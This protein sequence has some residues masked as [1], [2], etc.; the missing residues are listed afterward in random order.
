MSTELY[1]LYAVIAA[2][3]LA[4]FAFCLALIVR[5]FAKMVAV[6]GVAFAAG[7]GGFEETV[8]AHKAEI[9][10][11]RDL[12]DK[13]EK[14]EIYITSFDGLKLHGVFLPNGGSRRVMLFV[15]GYRSSARHD[16]A[17]A[18]P[19]YIGRGYAILMIDQRAHGQSEGDHIT[20]GVHERRDICDFANE[21]DRRFGGDVQI[22]L[23]GISMGA[24]T[25]LFAANAG[26]PA[27]VRGIIAD[28][29]YTSPRDI[30]AYLL[31]EKYRLPAFPILPLVCR[32]L[33]K[34]TG[35]DFG[36]VSVANTL[37]DNRL[38]ILF[39][40]GEEDGFV[41][42]EMSEAAYEITPSQKTLVRVPGAPHACGYLVDRQ[43]CDAALDRF[44]GAV[45]EK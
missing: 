5:K 17:A 15:H 44:L 21:L 8:E 4:V 2:V 41:P 12:Y 30:L 10:A 18:L 23:D 13:L 34:L 28:S 43:N 7:F 3:I 36:S 14:E 6:R 33:R 25:V 38:P 9:D 11:G 45:F 1:I 29:G 24:A 16:F 40:H 42:I 20:L 26:L 32:R 22:V 19:Y 27:S 39:V 31:R 35:A 37:A